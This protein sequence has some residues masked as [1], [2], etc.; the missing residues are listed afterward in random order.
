MKVKN[1]S[2]AQENR[3]DRAQH[4]KAIGWRD[5]FSS[6]VKYARSTLFFSVAVVAASSM[7]E[8]IG[9]LLLIPI[10]D[11]IF[12]SASSG[13]AVSL[14]IVD[15]MRTLGFS[16]KFQ[17]LS[18][19]SAIFLGLM[20]IRAFV[21]LYRDVLLMRLS[22]GYV[23]HIRIRSFSAMAAADWPT[24]KRLQRSHLLDDMTINVARIAAAMSFMSGGIVTILLLV[25]YVVS[26]FVVNIWV[27]IM[28]LLICG[29]TVFFASIWLKR[30]RNLGDSLTQGSR[31]IMSETTRF[32]DGL[33]AAK[34][35]Q[36]EGVFTAQFEHSIVTTRK[37]GTD[38]V[39]Q[40]ARSAR[41]V[42]MIGAVAAVTL[43]LFGYEVLHLTGPELLIMA[44]IVL[45]L[46]PNLVGMLSGLQSIAFAL[47]AF[48]TTE[49]IRLQVINDNAAKPSKRR[50]PAP[51]SSA[52]GPILVDGAVVCMGAGA[53]K[54][55]LLTTANF[56]L[57]QKGLVYVGGPS[58]SG[59]ST[60]V[61]LLAG[62]YLPASGNVTRNGLSLSID[63]R[64]IW[65]EAVAY[66]P[67][68]PFLFGGTVRENLCWPNITASDDD[69]W[70]ALSLAQAEPLV[71]QLPLQ[72]DEILYDNG[73]R[74]SG[75]QRQRL[76]IA[77][78][79][80]RPSNLLILDEATSALDP[81]IEA[82]VLDNLANIAQSKAVIIVS[83]SLA[84]KRVATQEIDI[85]SGFAALRV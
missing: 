40:K 56:T 62:L 57:E 68:E 9:L 46:N 15:G 78:A 35:C 61:E 2:H 10:A 48:E 22:Q 29:F 43:L 60:F 42:E 77:R 18:L 59:K 32:L 51:G 54:T 30:I 70:R 84:A 76:C 73:S 74:L 67:Q 26:A 31:Q 55:T 36:A 37:I 4:A 52:T 16:S 14:F 45:R 41:T 80:L 11:V 66:V 85:V 38:F 12:S 39:L 75:G 69:I 23:D 83:H 50:A 5:M 49:K 3:G 8:G 28:L 25:V 82:V 58:G 79:L 21:L 17:Q 81:D 7:L 33:K 64:T 1:V 47:P 53:E 71:R 6:I 44:A 27:G 65:Q 19:L 24:L 20:F 34:S 72:L 13:S 63:T